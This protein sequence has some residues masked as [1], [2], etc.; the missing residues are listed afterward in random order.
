M[1]RLV[2][3]AI[4]LLLINE[5]N[6]TMK[7]KLNVKDKSVVAFLEERLL[8]YKPNECDRHVV[9]HDVSAY[10][11]LK[12]RMYFKKDCGLMPGD[13]LKIELFDEAKM[14]RRRLI[15]TYTYT[16]EAY[17]DVAVM[18]TLYDF[19]VDVNQHFT[20]EQ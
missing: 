4:R 10:H 6:K 13:F 15:N 17:D 5:M 7:I 2:A 14:S 19:K 3:N 11:L 9:S 20:V 12:D 18:L 8:G 16:V 1:Q